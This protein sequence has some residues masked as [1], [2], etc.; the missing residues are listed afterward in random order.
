MITAE[1]FK[2]TIYAQNKISTRK[3]SHK[4][5][6]KDLSHLQQLTWH[7]SQH[8]VHKLH[9]RY[10]FIN[11][12]KRNRPCSNGIIRFW[13]RLIALD[14]KAPPPP[15]PPTHTHFQNWAKQNGIKILSAVAGKTCKTQ[16]G[17]RP[18][19]LA[20]IGSR[21][22]SFLPCSTR[23]RLLKTLDQCV[24]PSNNVR[25]ISICTRWHQ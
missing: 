16:G 14:T 8:K 20:P 17:K 1:Y 18:C 25:I 4:H 6:N 11:A 22:Q 19:Q 13:G 7:V 10:R 21:P 5:N 15:P 24:Y 3:T 12:R 9:H 23:N 2:N